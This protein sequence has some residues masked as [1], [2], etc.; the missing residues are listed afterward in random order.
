LCEGRADAAAQLL[1]HTFS[2]FDE[3]GLGESISR[4]EIII[5]SFESVIPQFAVRICDR[6]VRERGRGR[7]RLRA[8]LAHSRA[9][10]RSS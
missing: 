2:L 10:A 8:R 7:C 4:L 3:L 6:V 1:G 5:D 9:R